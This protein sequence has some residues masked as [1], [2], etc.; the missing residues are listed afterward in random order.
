[1]MRGHTSHS[2][3]YTACTEYVYFSMILKAICPV[4]TV[5]LLYAFPQVEK[6]RFFSDQHLIVR[7]SCLLELED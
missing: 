5:G 1:M 4:N 3:F 2:E 6:N 7:E